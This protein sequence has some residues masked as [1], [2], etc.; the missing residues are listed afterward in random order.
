MADMKIL[1]IPKIIH[2]LISKNN[3]VNK[4]AN[5]PRN[6]RINGIACIVFI[7]VNYIVDI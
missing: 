4:V 7:V 5:E 1:T 3:P 6:N 2:N